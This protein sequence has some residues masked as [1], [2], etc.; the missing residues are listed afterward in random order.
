MEHQEVVLAINPGSTTTKLAL[1]HRDGIIAEQLHEHEVEELSKFASVYA[2]FT[3]RRDLILTFLT[4][5][6]IKPG[7]LSLVMGRGGLLHPLLSGVYR[8]NPMMLRDLEQARYGEHACNLG[9]PLADAIAKRYGCEALIADPVVVDEM[10]DLARISGMPDIPRKSIFHALNQKYVARKA[11]K[12]LHI[13]YDQAHLIVAH[14]GGG[15]SVGAHCCGRVIDVNN[16]LDGEGPLT[17]ERSGGL[18]AGDLVRLVYSGKYNHEQLHKKIIGFGGLYAYTGTRDLK[19]LA[20]SAQSGKREEIFWVDVL[21]YQIC[22]EIASLFAVL[23]SRVDAVV[24]TGSIAHNTYITERINGRIG[25]LA[26][27][28]IFPGEGEMQSL[29]ENAFAVIDGVREVMDY[30]GP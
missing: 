21:V 16:A 20:D 13:P 8:V 7:T 15:I 30:E 27:L 10:S 11:A 5:Q 17:P 6:H 25:T 3:F 23:N 22:K 9:A 18:P 26:P 2:Q 12:Q 1:F 28:L 19:A 14:L 4:E 29:A 24:L